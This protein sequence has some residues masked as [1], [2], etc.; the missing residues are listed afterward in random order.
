M[1]TDMV[2]RT[3]RPPRMAISSSV[4]EQIARPASTPPSA[5]EPVSPMKILAGEVF[6]HRKPRQAPISA[7]ETTARSRGSLTS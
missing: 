3:N 1:T 2:I 7:E 6:H 4:R 5:S